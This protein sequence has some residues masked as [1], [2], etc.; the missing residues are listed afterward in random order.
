V[1]CFWQLGSPKGK[2]LESIAPNFVRFV[3]RHY[4][5]IPRLIEPAKRTES[6]NFV[7]TADWLRYQ[8]KW[9]S[10]NLNKR[11][12]QS[13]VIRGRQSSRPARHRRNP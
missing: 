3:I 5:R 7:L 13:A 12:L 11:P 4:N 10:R 9:P 8:R 1:F 2:V 6:E